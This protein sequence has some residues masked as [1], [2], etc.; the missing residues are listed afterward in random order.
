MDL[1]E[2]PVPSALAERAQVLES[3]LGKIALEFG[4]VAFASSFGA[5]DMV[6]T[7]AIFAAKLPIA[8]FTLDTGR[9][10]DATLDLLLRTRR[11]YATEIE[12]FRPDDD[13]VARYVSTHGAN[14][15]YESVDL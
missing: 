15:F 12:V 2:K 11:H 10:P 4:R 8:I 14:A 5:E 3:D 9:L 7:D 13:A 6:V 1:S